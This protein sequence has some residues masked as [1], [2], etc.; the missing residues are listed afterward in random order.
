MLMR[1][2]EPYVRA[3]D[4]KFSRLEII[5]LAT[6]EEMNPERADEIRDEL[7]RLQGIFHQDFE[8]LGPR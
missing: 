6:L 4:K 1:A 8:D 7:D 2:L 5:L 3:L